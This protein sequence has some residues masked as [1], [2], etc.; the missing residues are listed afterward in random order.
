M[1]VRPGGF[2]EQ[3]LWAEVRRE[4]RRLHWEA[5]GTADGSRQD[6]ALEMAFVAPAPQRTVEWLRRHVVRMAEGAFPFGSKPAPETGVAGIGGWPTFQFGA[7]HTFVHTSSSGGS[8]R[9]VRSLRTAEPLSHVVARTGLRVTPV[10]LAGAKARPAAG[11]PLA[12][13]GQRYPVTMLVPSPAPFGYTPVRS[14]YLPA[15]LRSLGVSKTPPQVAGAESLFDQVEQWLRERDFLPSKSDVIPETP[16]K[17]DVEVDVTKALGKVTARSVQTNRLNNMRELNQARSR[18]GLFSGLEEMIQNA[19]EPTFELPTASGVQRV[20]M[21]LTTGLPYTGQDVKPRAAHYWALPDVQTLSYIG[22]TT[23]GDGQFTSVPSGWHTGAA[24]EVVDPLKSA[25]ST[26]RL[27]RVSGGFIHSR[28]SENVKG[29]SSGIR[30]E[31]YQ[32]SPTEDG[33]RLFRMTPVTF[34]MELS[35][36]HGPTPEPKQADGFV[37]LAVP[38]YRTLPEPSITSGSGAVTV[39]EG[40]AA[41]TTVT[42]AAG[43]TAGPASATGPGG[44]HVRGADEEGGGLV[45]E[46]AVPAQAV[47]DRADGDERPSAVQQAPWYVETDALGEAAF[48]GVDP[49]SADQV[50]FWADRVGGGA[51]HEDDSAKLTEAIRQGLR[52]LLRTGDPE[53]WRVLFQKGHLVVADGRLVWLRP[54]L[55]DVTVGTQPVGGVREYTVSFASLSSGGKTAREVSTGLDGMLLSFLSLGTAVGSVFIPGLP[56]IGAGSSHAREVERERQLIAGRKLYVNENTRFRGGMAVRVFVDGAERPND[57]ALPAR[58]DVDFPE[59]FT[60]ADAPRPDRTAPRTGG[61][62][63]GQRPPQATEVINAVDTIPAVTALQRRLLGARMPAES[64]RQ[65]MTEV[66]EHLTESSARNR[67]RLLLSSGIP[68]GQLRVKM[69]KKSFKGHFAISARITSLQHIGDSDIAVRFDTGA[70]LSVKPGRLAGSKAFTGFDFSFAG[71]TAPGHQGDGKKGFV[72]GPT[73]VFDFSR[74]TG[75]GATEQALGHTVLNTT[76]PQ[77]RYR[78]GLELTVEIRST[79]HDLEPVSV[80]VESEVSVARRDAADFEERLTGAVQTPEPRPRPPQEGAA[81]SPAAQDGAGQDTAAARPNVAVLQ[82]PPGGLPPRSAY[83]RPKRLGRTMKVDPGHREPLALA[84]RKGT[85]FGKEATLPGSELVHDQL[86]AVLAKVHHDALPERQRKQRPDWSNVDLE[87]ATWFS[88]P[89]LE[90]NLP[91]LVAGIEHTVT[92]GGR[93]YALGAKAYL[94]ERLERDGVYKM[95]VNGRAL[96]AASAAGHR[97]AEFGIKAAFG[98]GLRVRAFDWLRFTVGAAA[99][100]AEYVYTRKFDLSGGAKSYRRTETT[101]NVDE[102]NYNVIYELWVRPVGG[103]AETWWIDQRGDVTARVVVP[104]EHR[105]AVPLTI[106]E[107]RAVGRATRIRYWPQEPEADFRAGGSSG[108]YPSFFVMPRLSR[109]AAGMYARTNGLPDSWLADEAGWP[110]EIKELAQPDKLAEYFPALADTSGRIVD[111]PKGADGMK[112]ALRIRLRGYRPRHVN[113]DGGTEIEQYAQG[114]AQQKTA[115]EHKGGAGGTFSAG[116]QFRLGAEARPPH[117]LSPEDGLVDDTMPDGDAVPDMHGALP[118]VLHAVKGAGG[119]DSSAEN[120]HSWGGRIQVTGHG[121]ATWERKREK[122]RELGSIEI[123]RAT[124]G[125]TTHTYRMDPVFEVTL[126]RWKGSR[127]TM[128]TRYLRVRDAMD[129]LVPERRIFDLGL[130]APGVTPPVPR[131]PTRHVPPA[132]LKGMSYPELLNGDAVLDRIKELLRERGLLRAFFDG[133]DRPNLL[134]RIIESAYS[135]DALR[136]QYN[137]GLT[138]SGVIRW[139]PVPLPFGGTHYLWIRVTARTGAATEQL[140]RPEVKL[141]LRDEALDEPTKSEGSS[142]GW[143]AGFDVRTRAGREGHGQGHGGP[144]VGGGYERKSGHGSEKIA[145]K[146]EIHRAGT[147]EGSLE[148]GHPLH[149]GVE[150]GL[151]V[152][153]PEIL[154]VPLRLAKAAVVGLGRLTQAPELGDAWYGHRPFIWYHV[155]EPG[156]DGV[157]GDVRL[158]VPQHIAVLDAPAEPIAPVVGTDPQWVEH[159]PWQGQ[160]P[161]AVNALIENLHPWDAAFAAAVERW[162]GPVTSPYGRPRDLERPGVWR[163]PGVDFTTKAGLRYQHFTGEDMLRS[164]IKQVLGNAYLVPVLERETIV[165]VE[166]TRAEVIGP[167]DGTR[168]KGRNYTQ[169]SETG[170][171]QHENSRGRHLGF[172]PEAGGETGSAKR[173]G[174]GLGEYGREHSEE[175]SGEL[176]VTEERNKEATRNYRHY[177]FDVD[178]YLT[179]R[180][181]VIRVHAPGGLHGML[182]LEDDPAGGRRLAD[183]LETR[184]PHLFGPKPQP[185]EPVPGTSLRRRWYEPKRIRAFFH[186]EIEN[187]KHRFAAPATSGDRTPVTSGEGTPAATKRWYKAPALARRHL[188]WLRSRSTVQESRPDEVVTGSTSGPPVLPDLP[189]GLGDFDL[190]WPGEQTDALTG[191]LTGESGGD[192]VSAGAEGGSGSAADAGGVDGSGLTRPQAAALERMAL[193]PVHVL[194]TGDAVVHALQAVAPAET[195]AA[196]GGRPASPPELRAY[197]A[198]ALAADL[199]SG[200]PRFWPAVGMPDGAT[201][202]RRRAFVAALTSPDGGAEADEVFLA[203]AAAVLRLRIAVLEPDGGTVEFG[204]ADGRPVVLAELFAPGPYTAAWAGTEPIVDGGSPAGP[205]APPAPRPPVRPASPVGD[206]VPPGAQNAASADTAARTPVVNL[207]ADPFL[208]TASDGAVRPRVDDAPTHP[209]PSAPA[210]RASP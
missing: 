194:A 20:K 124:Y 85:G 163:I 48:T 97:K 105:P 62:R 59:P 81:T 119:Q 202:D 138:G 145:K 45:S 115:G 54:V 154:N 47:P 80:V 44:K 192:E 82:P 53:E 107:I 91:A 112:Q 31:Y 104:H 86:R 90:S 7:N 24:G 6:D 19:V 142:R 174:T 11:T 43:S 148:Y 178:V 13:A 46:Q 128:M 165:G 203:A 127:R 32:L 141:T 132:L 133:E 157:K 18:L 38:T 198:D 140:D 96:M 100:R 158:L 117:S 17:V 206:V 210:W 146:L 79:T 98:G 196:A 169:K 56:M 72:H 166:I 120:D 74:G 33:P 111:L 183:G 15:H 106:E 58:F 155:D 201:D 1:V 185:A 23:S 184:L 151:S 5:E 103:Q 78:S 77:S 134:W 109:L 89:G 181:G 122:G 205:P 88:R 63:T 189:E 131:P 12:D 116:P 99:G 139:V 208:G 84:A 167:V 207:G 172:G 200:A 37:R 195:S 70:G 118:E 40:A 144:E 64:V 173:L 95:T 171:E 3:A 50:E 168:F 186:K 176:G 93:K 137:G 121:G 42:R 76:G 126:F 87:M 136:N 57:I 199:N 149:F 29:P 160:D 2:E 61:G 108:L 94:M 147:R 190:E 187:L 16:G 60:S 34:Q 135:S 28:R 51:H 68:T 177:R 114:T 8:A 4:L 36:S 26:Q 153:P 113:A 73:F 39:R 129:L 209:G 197:L 161:D 83:V 130:T 22:S 159:G 110:L 156:P 9:T 49:W 143:D 71:L 170:K 52:D 164:N 182:P 65:V 30:H 67:S 92:L 162:A 66:L 21:K 125:G 27:S 25:R 204:S 193:R 75:Y 180:H 14:R 102:H 123:S 150:L 41:E 35:V 152:E 69:P 101:E 179:G 55:R 191:A 175:Q 10:R 188:S